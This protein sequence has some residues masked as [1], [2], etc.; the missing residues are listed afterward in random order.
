MIAVRL[1]G[2]LGNQLFQYA[3]IYAAAKKLDTGFYLDKSI[4][5]FLLP[6]YFNV[7][8]DFNWIFDDYLFSIR[9][10]KNIF[11]YH[12]R[13]KFYQASKFFFMLK[14]IAFDNEKKPVVQLD[15]VKKQALYYG[16]FQ[17]EDYFI[18]SRPQLINLFT[19]KK[20]H[21][22]EF[23]MIKGLLNIPDN[24]TVVHIRRGDYISHGFALDYDYFHKA[25]KSLHKDNNFY[26]FISDEPK[27]VVQEFNYIESKYI[28]D[29]KEIIDFQFLSNA[30][31]CILSNSTFSWWG[32]YLNKNNPPVIVPEYWL[33]FKE[34]KENPT[35]II[36]KNFISFS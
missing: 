10:Y 2:R 4:D 29:N 22:D 8:K 18:S 15:I 28:S 36:P 16:F 25:I 6:E 11:S 35:H 17:S 13:I 33:G 34:K 32:A 20:K 23:K 19:I 7:K 14:T 3:F 24:Y 27:A 31:A 12:A 5:C 26:I 21:T 9:G 30:S 1:E